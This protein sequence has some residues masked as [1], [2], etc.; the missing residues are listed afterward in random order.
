M[1]KYLFFALTAMF[2]SMISVQYSYGQSTNNADAEDNQTKFSDLINNNPEYYK[3]FSTDTCYTF[4]KI[5]YE[6]P[7]TVVAISDLENN[8][9]W[10]GIDLIKADGYRIDRYIPDSSVDNMKVILSKQ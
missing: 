10:H 7:Q 5:F 9:T 8:E 3:C 1:M 4:L 2:A 6:S